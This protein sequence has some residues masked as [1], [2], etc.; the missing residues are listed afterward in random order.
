MVYA[1]LLDVLSTRLFLDLSYIPYW[2]V[3]K[4]SKK[5]REKEKEKAKEGGD[6]Q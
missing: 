4:D 1:A 5:K 2:P 6:T 3:P